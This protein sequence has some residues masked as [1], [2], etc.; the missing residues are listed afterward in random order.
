MTLPIVRA[1]QLV[2][3]RVASG[4]QCLSPRAPVNTP[5]YSYYIQ[6]STQIGDLI[7]NTA[8]KLFVALITAENAFNSQLSTFYEEKYQ[9]MGYYM[10][11]ML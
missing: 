1:P 9:L 2:A 11:A 10:H 5:Y 6:P 7:S 4:V 8:C 3:C